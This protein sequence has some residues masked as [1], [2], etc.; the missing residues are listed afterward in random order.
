MATNIFVAFI[1][2][3]RGRGAKI[4]HLKITKPQAKPTFKKDTH[5]KMIYLNSEEMAYYDYF[6]S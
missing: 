2:L 3:I 5:K 1:M 4:G 6:Y